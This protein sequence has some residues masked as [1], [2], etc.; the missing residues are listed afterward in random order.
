MRACVWRQPDGAL[1]LVES[2]RRVPNA[3]RRWRSDD[4]GASWIEQMPLQ[5]TP[6]GACAVAV[7]PDG[8]AWLAHEGG[9]FARREHVLVRTLR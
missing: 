6:A 1:M 2:A 4:G 3:L 8:T 7:A 5:M 9:D